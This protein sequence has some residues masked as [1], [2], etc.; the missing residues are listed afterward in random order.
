MNLTQENF[1]RK[2]QK[3]GSVLYFHPITDCDMSIFHMTFLLFKKEK[4]NYKAQRIK[5]QGQKKNIY[6]FGKLHH[7]KT[8]NKIKQK[9]LINTLENGGFFWQFNILNY[10]KYLNQ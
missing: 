7:Y 6:Q 9:N 1:M 2:W 5:Q 4:H 8:C 3:L 10:F